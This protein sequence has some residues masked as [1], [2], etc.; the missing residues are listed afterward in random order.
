VD[1]DA[2][3]TQWTDA[4]RQRFVAEVDALVEA[5][6]AHSAAVLAQTGAESGIPA[7]FDA[8]DALARAV[9]TYGDA[10]FDLTGV[11]PPV[12]VHGHD[13]EPEED[14]GE[15]VEVVA[16]VRVLRRADYAV[17]DLDAVLEAGRAAYAEVWP[18]DS[19]EDA[20]ADV[21]DLGR[22]LYQVQ[23]AD[24]P[25]ALEDVPGLLPV[26]S[27]TWYVDVS[28]QEEAPEDPFGT[29]GSRLLFRLDEVFGDEDGD[30]D[31]DEDDDEDAGDRDGQEVAGEQGPATH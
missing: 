20:A 31:D 16:I 21:S 23:H 15:E 13:E 30:E 4:A 25:A 22:A 8:G 18:D 29:D 17:T 14:G 7:L 12:H 19:P 9:D 1:E 2:V 3:E 6:R 27:T 26:G 11:F 28:D 10:Q 24:G 5:V